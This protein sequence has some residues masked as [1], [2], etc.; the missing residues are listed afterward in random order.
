MILCFFILAYVELFDLK[1]S[2]SS[3]IAASYEFSLLC[4]I[5]LSDEATVCSDED[6]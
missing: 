1:H 6:C 4:A 5:F 3:K 2:Q